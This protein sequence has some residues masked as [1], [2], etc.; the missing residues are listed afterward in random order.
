MAIAS[1]IFIGL[2]AVGLRRR[3]R[4]LRRI[5]ECDLTLASKI[6]YGFD[7]AVEALLGRRG[8]AA[9]GTREY[10]M[11]GGTSV[12][13]RRNSTDRKVFEEIFVE[14]AYTPYAKAIARNAPI[15]L[16]DLGANIGLSAVALARE[17]Q[18]VAIVAVEPD[19]G[20]FALLRENVRRAGLA[21]QC[22]AVQAFAGVEQGFAELVDS[23]N[24]AWGLRMGAPTVTGIPVLPLE[25]IIAI[26]E[27]MAGAAESRAARTVLKCDIEGAEASL[28][29][30]IGQWEGRVHYM[31][32]ELH[33]EFLSVQE[34][35][36]CLAASRYHWRIGGTIPAEAILALIGLERLELKAAAQSRHA[37]SS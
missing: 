32:L 35:H 14:H 34:L 30:R 1:V 12:V 33:T 25:E 27:G 3:Y 18:P 9:T 7:L 22:A 15:L 24:G 11:R 6:H 26:G 2:T 4:K 10:Q 13:L 20:N 36:A 31:I 16:V 5:A 21:D 37:V 19:R 28:F 8:P 23:G 17:L 29:Q